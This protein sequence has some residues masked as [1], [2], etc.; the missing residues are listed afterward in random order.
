MVAYSVTQGAEPPV[1]VSDLGRHLPRNVS[2][3][4]GPEEPNVEENTVVVDVVPDVVS[5]VVP[6]TLC[7]AKHEPATHV[8]PSTQ[9]SL[10]WQ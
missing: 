9:S 2:E 6:L 3:P 1:T 5:V 4:A 8:A 7:G 10:V